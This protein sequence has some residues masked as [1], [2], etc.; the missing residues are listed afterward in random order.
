VN[1]EIGDDDNAIAM[2]K[3]CLRIERCI[4]GTD[5]TCDI[6]DSLQRVGRLHQRRGE[7]DESLS[8]F[9]EALE[10]LR[11]RGESATVAKFLNLIGNVYLQKAEIGEMM[12]YYTEA[13]RI[14]REKSTPPNEVLVIA[15]YFMYGLSKLH[16]MCAAVA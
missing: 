9:K 2:Y 16:P 5:Q 12:Q 11:A 1:E 3:E 6:I 13:S 8:Y 7:L 10:C 15:G 14:F 4:L